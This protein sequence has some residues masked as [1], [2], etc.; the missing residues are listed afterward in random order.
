ME[1]RNAAIAWAVVAVTVWS[2]SFAATKRLLVELSPDTLLFARSAIGAAAVTTAL[3]AG[4]RMRVLPAREWPR[5][6]LLST[7]GLGLTQWLQAHALE[8]STSAATA[9]LVALNPVVTAVLASALISERLAGKRIGLAL[10][11]G[12]ALLVVNRGVPLAEMLDYP[13]TR[14]DLLT[15]MSTL[16]WSLYTIYGRAFVARHP[17]A[18]VT[19]H[20]LI[21]A[22]LGFAAPF[23][24]ERGWREIGALSDAGWLCLLYLGLGCSGLAFLLYYAALEHLEASRLAAFIYLEPLFA[25]AISIA[26]LG[27]PL[28][29]RVVAGGGAIL[30]GVYL[31]ARVG[32]RTAAT[33]TLV[34]PASAS[35]DPGSRPACRAE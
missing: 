28:S 34:L 24:L 26:W 2:A 16:F 14:G 3:A 17:P 4:G 8:R 27:E 21:V 18:V 31:V 1:R 7:L 10:A 30:T 11:F 6:A 32:S 23:A 29:A 5:L 35:S 20:L 13:S 22:T 19:A 15:V 33:V 9:W 12:G 25:Q